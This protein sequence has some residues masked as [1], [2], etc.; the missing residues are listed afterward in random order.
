MDD[1]ASIAAL[2][3]LLGYVKMNS[4]DMPSGHMN[5]VLL[6]VLRGP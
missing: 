3:S 5:A 1:L 2:N 4:F 6:F